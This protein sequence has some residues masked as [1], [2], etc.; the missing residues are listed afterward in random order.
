MFRKNL[1]PRSFFCH[2]FTT[3][4]LQKE[5]VLLDDLVLVWYIF[6]IVTYWSKSDRGMFKIFHSLHCWHL[7]EQ[8]LHRTPHW[9]AP[10]ANLAKY[11]SR[12]DVLTTKLQLLLCLMQ[13]IRV[14]FK[15]SKKKNV[16]QIET[17]IIIFPQNWKTWQK[18]WLKSHS[19]S[20]SV[21]TLVIWY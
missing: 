12:A 6:I 19:N 21:Y 9:L 10:P 2:S 3:R 17:I 11:L 18:P 15:E 20:V 4:D 13:N 8:H 1:H 7:F 5:K 16:L 14:A